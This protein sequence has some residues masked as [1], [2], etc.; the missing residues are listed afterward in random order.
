M[1]LVTTGGLTAVF[2]RA[3]ASSASATASGGQSTGQNV[4]VVQNPA[5]T[6]PAAAGPAT[7]AAVAP[8]ASTTVAAA[9][10]TGLADGTY[11]GAASQNRW[12]T[13]Q[14][15]MTVSA[16][17][18]ADVTTLQYPDSERKSVRINQSALP[19]LTSEALSAQSSKIHG[20]SGATYTS[21]SYV[22]SLQSAIDQATT[23][24]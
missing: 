21:R 5:S 19:V 24:A 11:V 3:D 1:S 6:A 2:A 22:E 7:P 10:P 12:G 4:A 14:V 16:G 9:T 17:K 8:A 13:V 15:Q 20:V 23:A 18:I